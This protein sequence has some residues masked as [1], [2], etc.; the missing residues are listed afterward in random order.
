MPMTASKYWRLV[1]LDGTGQRR[2]EE[3]AIA[4]A[5]FQEKFPELVV[6]ETVADS[7]IQRELMQH[8]RT[9]ANSIDRQGAEYCLRCFISQQIEQVCVQLEVKFGAEH[10]F[11]RYDLF[12]FVLDDDLITDQR[13]AYA[14]SRRVATPYRSLAIEILA[15]FDIDRA[16]LS[17]WV[18]R[19]VRHHRELRA[20]LHEHGVFLAT[21]WGILNDTSPELLR[22]ILTEFYRLTPAEVTPAYDLL[23]S[24]HAV[25]RRDR[26][27]QR[28]LGRLKNKE[29]CA[30]PSHDQLTRIA[31]ALPTETFAGLR[32]PERIL[33]QLQTIASQLRQY[34]LHRL[35]KTLPTEPIDRP[36]GEALIAKLPAAEAKIDVEEETFLAFYRKQV[37][38]CLDR[39]LAQVTSDR[40]TY[41]QRK[42]SQAAQQ[43]LMALELFHCQGQSMSEI[44]PQVGLQAQFQVTRLLKLKEFRAAVRSRLL[45]LLFQAVIEKARTYSDPIRLQRLNQQIE[46]ILEEQIDALIQQT[47]KEGAVAKKHP[48]RSLFARRLC[49]HLDFRSSSP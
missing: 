8:L 22:S 35:G 37:L 28:Q 15:T 3:I 49:Q 10:G 27:Q 16:G 25:Y 2:V 33:S 29:V 32:S 26:L 45:Q 43:F 42:K 36:G 34:R 38:D 6:Q 1:R 39:S 14:P 18:T 9:A 21:D 41:L 23:Q 40:I 17:T 13:F 24:Y 46:V 4:R 19:Q 31:A 30:A 47:E 7:T 20:F 44:A 48:L 12:P 5:F 11:T